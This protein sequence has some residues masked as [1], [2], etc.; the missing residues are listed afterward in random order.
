MV[1]IGDGFHNIIHACKT[2]QVIDLFKAA[3]I[4]MKSIRGQK[5]QKKTDI[6]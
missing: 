1:L 2:E 3:H 6:N 5:K 4:D